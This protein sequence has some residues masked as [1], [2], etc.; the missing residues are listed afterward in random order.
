MR[1]GFLGFVSVLAALGSAVVTSGDMGQSL[2]ATTCNG[3]IVEFCFTPGQDLGPVVV[4]GWAVVNP[5]VSEGVAGTVGVVRFIIQPGVLE[6]PLVGVAL[7]DGD[8][9]AAY[10]AVPFPCV[11]SLALPVQAVGADPT[12]TPTPLTV[13]EGVL[14][15]LTVKV[16]GAP[17]AVVPAYVDVVCAAGSSQFFDSDCDGFDTSAELSAGSN[18]FYA[19]S[20]PTHK[21]VGFPGDWDAD[22]WWD[23]LE[24]TGFNQRHPSDPFEQCSTPWDERPHNVWPT[25]Y[26]SCEPGNPL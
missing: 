10:S 8:L 12:I 25:D 2:N 7:G 13:G 11:T 15:T 4:P 5:G 22:S 21:G 26:Q 1:R 3:T 18:P 14:G 20:T 17:V 19:G 9:C 16:N 23:H 6:V 24:A